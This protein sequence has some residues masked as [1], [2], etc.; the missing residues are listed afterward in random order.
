MLNSINTKIM[1]EEFTYQEISRD[2]VK[3][4]A[5]KAS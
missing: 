2:L 1:E 5:E 4:T 3:T